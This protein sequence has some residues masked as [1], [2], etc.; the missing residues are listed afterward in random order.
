MKPRGARSLRK[1]G[2]SWEYAYSSL[3]VGREPRHIAHAVQ[4]LPWDV[5]FERASTAV[6]HVLGTALEIG[7]LPP[8]E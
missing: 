7:H 4:L 2:V 8:V 5:L 1:T 6:D 3:V